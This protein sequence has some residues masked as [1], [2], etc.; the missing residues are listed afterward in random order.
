M[1]RYSQGLQCQYQ[2]QSEHLGIRGAGKKIFVAGCGL[3]GLS[4][5]LHLQRL[6]DEQGITPRPDVRL[7]ERDSSPEMRAGQGYSLSVRGEG[8][9]VRSG[10]LWSSGSRWID[11]LKLISG[12]RRQHRQLRAAQISY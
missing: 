12:Q 11:S 7:F 10:S 4:F 1:G 5:A 6:C 8:L 9:Q 2:R 3:G